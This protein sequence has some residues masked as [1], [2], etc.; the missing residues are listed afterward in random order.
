KGGIAV[1]SIPTSTNEA[2]GKV[3]ERGGVRFTTSTNEAAG[4]GDGYELVNF[5]CR[6]SPLLPAGAEEDPVYEVIS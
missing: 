1:N 2:Y 5:P 6:E 4:E 3:R